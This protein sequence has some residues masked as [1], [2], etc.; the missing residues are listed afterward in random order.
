MFTKLSI[1]PTLSHVFHYPWE[2]FE[3]LSFILYFSELYCIF[4]KV[5]NDFLLF[6][7]SFFDFWPIWWL[8]G[9]SWSAFLSLWHLRLEFNTVIE[10]AWRVLVRYGYFW[11][12]TFLLVVFMFGCFWNRNTLIF[13]SLGLFVYERFLFLD[14]F[15]FNF[16]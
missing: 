14:F 3:K 11:L 6:K 5:V 13:L 4:H 1:L 12:A 7:S 15:L 16:L 2:R 9:F 10:N 8:N